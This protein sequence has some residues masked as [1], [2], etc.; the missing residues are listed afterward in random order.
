MKSS[1]YF[2]GFDL[3]MITKFQWIVINLALVLFFLIYIN[4]RSKSL[5]LTSLS[6][7]R[8]VDEQNRKHEKLSYA[9]SIVIYNRIPKTGS[10][11]LTN[12]IM[13]NLCHRNG[14]NVIHL[15]LTRNRYLMN[16]VDQR[17]FIDNITNW[18]ERM[19]AVYHGHVAFINFNRFG[20][21]NPVYINLIREPLDRLISYYYFLRYGDNYRVGLKRSRAGNNETFDQCIARKGH[22]CDMKQMWLQIPYF[23]GTHHFCSEVGNNRAL[24]QA[25]VNL[26]NYYLLVG[27]SNQMRHFIELLELLLPK[28]FRDALKNFDSLDEKHANLRHTNLKIP[29]NKAT[30]EAIRNDPVYIMEREFY[31]FAQKQ[32]NEMRRRMLDESANELLPP[33][34]HYEKIK[35][36]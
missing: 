30:V 33:Q 2:P 20:L 36:V 19:P 17:R 27:L 14:F 35:P 23:C 31:D 34:F 24:E 28:F 22:D 7:Q 8:K 25:K 1:L 10:T 32:F 4:L 16:I 18:K 9:S 11:T 21:P 13:Y 29:P 3:L 5:C 6:Q 12:A 26:I 15:N